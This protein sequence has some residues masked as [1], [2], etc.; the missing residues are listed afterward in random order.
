M[1]SS[2]GSNMA[3]GSS[4]ASPGSPDS[5]HEWDRLSV[6]TWSQTGCDTMHFA[7]E[8]ES[9]GSGCACVCLRECVCIARCLCLSLSASFFSAALWQHRAV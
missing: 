8:D 4:T 7:D 2:L 6:A 9:R 1:I 3:R 5:G